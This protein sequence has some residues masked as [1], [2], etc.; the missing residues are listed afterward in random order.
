[1]RTEERVQESGVDMEHEIITCDELQCSDKC[2]TAQ[3]HFQVLHTKKSY[4]GAVVSKCNINFEI[5][6]DEK[7]VKIFYSKEDVIGNKQPSF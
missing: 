3:M 5:D 1:M 7:A 4:C 6:F 2:V